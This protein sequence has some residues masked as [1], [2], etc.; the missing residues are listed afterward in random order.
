MTALAPHHALQR[1]LVRMQYDPPFAQ[2]VLADPLPVLAPLGL[3]EREAGWLRRVD[4]RLYAHDP[5]KRRRLLQALLQELKAAS[6]IALAE[7]RRIAFLDGFFASQQFHAAIA[8]RGSL[9]AAYGAYLL[10]AGLRAP[11]LPGVVA[12][13]AQLAACRRD[14]EAQGG[15]DW[16][17]PAIPAELGLVRRAPGVAVGRHSPDATAAIQ[18]VEQYL[19]EVGLVPALVLAD[20]A[21]RLELPPPA[22]APA[23]AL[24][25]VPTQAGISLVELDDEVFTALD[26]AGEPVAAATLGLELARELLEGEV[27]IAVV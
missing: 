11:Q 5:L 4:P 14:L 26:R 10:A 9:A 23:V 7:T 1:L 17:A 22:G 27:L 21:P 20:D 15:V 13:E 24:G 16:R 8:Q 3:G 6:A 18:A 12:V 19:F 2:R 25:F